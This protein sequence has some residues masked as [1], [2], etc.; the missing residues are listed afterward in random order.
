MTLV[1]GMVLTVS[2]CACNCLFWNVWRLD[3]TIKDR[4][5]CIALKLLRY[6]TFP[7]SHSE[8]FGHVEELTINAGTS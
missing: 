4:F 5:K 2:P 6:C 7:F 8:T 3:T 1:S